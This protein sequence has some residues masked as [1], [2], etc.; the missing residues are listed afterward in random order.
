MFI[1]LLFLKIADALRLEKHANKPGPVRLVHL[2]VQLAV[3]LPVQL[4]VQLAVPLAVQRA[5]QRAAQLAVQLAV[6]LGVQLAVQLAVGDARF[7][8]REVSP[9]AW[10]RGWLHRW[11]RCVSP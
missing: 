1:F 10:R 8:N 3:Q 7:G 6:R 5:V 9:F 2:A 4:A 11:L